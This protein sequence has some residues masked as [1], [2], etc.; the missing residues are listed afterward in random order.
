VP[1]IVTHEDDEGI[2]LAEDIRKYRRRG[3]IGLRYGV[4]RSCV[5]RFE[6]RRG[7]SRLAAGH[8]RPVARPIPSGSSTD[9]M[10]TCFGSFDRNRGR[11]Q[12]MTTWRVM[13]P[14]LSQRVTLLAR[15]GSSGAGCT[16]PSASNALDVTMCWPLAGIPQPNVQ[17]L[18]AK[19]RLFRLWATGPKSLA[20]N[21]G[22][23]SMRTSTAAIG[24]PQAAPRT[25]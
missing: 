3:F 24:A 18:H 9:P 16:L 2:I 10:T 6:T 5:A 15:N 21:H 11:D 20:G 8:Q 1:P 22:P 19:P 13:C 7:H 12:G 25:T 23:L 14:L 17:N 4:M